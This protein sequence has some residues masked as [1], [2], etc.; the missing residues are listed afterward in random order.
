[1]SNSQTPNRNRRTANRT[2]T[3][4]EKHCGRAI[5]GWALWPVQTLAQ[6]VVRRKPDGPE[7]PSSDANFCDRTSSLHTKHLRSSPRQ[8]R[9]FTKSHE[10]MTFPDCRRTRDADNSSCRVLENRLSVPPAR[11]PLR[12]EVG[13][14]RHLFTS[15]RSRLESACVT[16]RRCD[17]RLPCEKVQPCSMPIATEPAAAGRSRAP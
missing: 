13:S 2:W 4:E 15:H 17:Y 10:V 6:R 16:G 5:G 8:S 7:C 3:D 12:S 14:R 11:E 1:M 9:S